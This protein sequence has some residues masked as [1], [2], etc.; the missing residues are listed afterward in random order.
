[1]SVK[2]STVAEL[3]YVDGA[4]YSYAQIEAA[5]RYAKERGKLD[6]VTPNPSSGNGL[7]WASPEQVDPYPEPASTVFEVD[8][9]PP[10]DHV[11]QNF[12]YVGKPSLPRGEAGDDYTSLKLRVAT[13]EGQVAALV[14]VARRLAN[15]LFQ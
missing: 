3:I 6:I 11:G 7:G 4:G 10:V 12:R 2:P 15:G 1:M 13:L 8:A 5:V 9:P 14:I